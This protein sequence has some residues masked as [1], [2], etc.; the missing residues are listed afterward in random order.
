MSFIIFFGGLVFLILTIIFSLITIKLK[1]Y[2]ITPSLEDLQRIFDDS[3]FEYRTIVRQ[4]IIAI[5]P[6]IKKLEKTNL[7]KAVWLGWKWV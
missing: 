7:N 4:I 5:L 2:D 6:A 1:H 3:R